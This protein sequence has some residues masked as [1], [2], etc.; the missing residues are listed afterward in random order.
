[1]SMGKKKQLRLTG[2][3]AIESHRDKVIH[4]DVSVVLNDGPAHTGHL[5]SMDQ[6]SLTIAN[7]RLATVKLPLDQ[8]SELYT[9]LNA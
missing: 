4:T 5:L 1:M 3:L 7:M 2:R 9:D 6:G 8:V